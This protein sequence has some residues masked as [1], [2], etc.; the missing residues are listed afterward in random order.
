MLLPPQS[1][2]RV[3]KSSVA[4]FIVLKI[5]WNVEVDLGT[6]DVDAACLLLLWDKLRKPKI[7]KECVALSL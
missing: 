5:V 4:W 6:H 2:W 3:C 7:K 1:T